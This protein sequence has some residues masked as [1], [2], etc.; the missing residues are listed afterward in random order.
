MGYNHSDIGALMGFAIAFGVAIVLIGRVCSARLGSGRFAIPA[1][2][3]HL[4]FVLVSVFLLLFLLLDAL[5]GMGG[6]YPTPLPAQAIGQLMSICF[7]LLTG[8]GIVLASGV[9][10]FTRRKNLAAAK[11]RPRFP[12]AAGGMGSLVILVAVGL[13]FSLSRLA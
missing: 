11:S 13:A 12:V 10:L 6:P 1:W 4:L 5:K 7:P 3:I 2:S 9:T 8:C